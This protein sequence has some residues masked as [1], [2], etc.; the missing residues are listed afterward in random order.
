MFWEKFEDHLNE[1]NKRINESTEKL[2]KKPIDLKHIGI[3]EGIVLASEPDL[4][5]ALDKISKYFKTDL[6]KL[7]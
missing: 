1:F 7:H 2:F 3:Y 5:L 6:K 4:H